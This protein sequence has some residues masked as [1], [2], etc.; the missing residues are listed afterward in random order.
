MCKV[1]KEHEMRKLETANS[2]SEQDTVDILVVD[3]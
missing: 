1:R 3:N 2:Q